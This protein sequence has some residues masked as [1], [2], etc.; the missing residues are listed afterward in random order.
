MNKLSYQ[1]INFSSPILELLF[2]LLKKYVAGLFP[3]QFSGLVLMNDNAVNDSMAEI[4]TAPIR[5]K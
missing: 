5:A 4:I 3:I 1:W 2:I